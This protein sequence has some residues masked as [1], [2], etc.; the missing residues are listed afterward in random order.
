[1]AAAPVFS[2]FPGMEMSVL[3]LTLIVV[4]VG[5]PGSLPGAALGSLIIGM[6]DTFGQVLVPEFASVTIYALMAVILL[7]RPHGLIP[8]RVQ[9]H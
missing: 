5:G 9:H 4:V 8:A 7:L 3:I 1:M 6:A 2:L